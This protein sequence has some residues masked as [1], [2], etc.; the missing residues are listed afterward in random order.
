M[1]E[2]TWLNEKELE[3]VVLGGWSFNPN[4]YVIAKL[5]NCA[6]GLDSWGRI[7]KSRFREDIDRCKKDLEYWRDKGDSYSVSQLC[8]CR[9]LIRT[10]VSFMLLHLK[11]EEKKQID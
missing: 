2:N 6:S 7:L 4:A 1:F 5:Q 11:E 3:D 8:L 10:L 9:K